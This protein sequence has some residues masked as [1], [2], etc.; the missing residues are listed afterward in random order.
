[1]WGHREKV[2]T[3]KLGGGLSPRT[4]S[5]GILIWDFPAS[6]TLRNTFLLFN[7]PSLWY[8]VTSARADW[9]TS[10]YGFPLP[11]SFTPVSQTICP[12]KGTPFSSTSPQTSQDIYTTFP[13]ITYTFSA[14]RKFHS[15]S[16]T[17]SSHWKHG[18]SQA[19]DT[20]LHLAQHTL[21]SGLWESLLGNRNQISAVIRIKPNNISGKHF[22]GCEGPYKCKI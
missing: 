15:P 21:L 6:R 3:Y 2:A 4:K 19:E 10:I 22:I 9:D 11:S 17:S 1:M 14:F 20:G 18:V 16:N 13:S 12:A 5:A 7:S 8:F